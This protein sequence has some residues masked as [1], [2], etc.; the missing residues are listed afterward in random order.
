MDYNKFLDEILTSLIHEDGSDLHLGAGR[1]PAVRINGQLILLSNKEI[2]K[3]EDVLSILKMIIGK[4]KTDKFLET[5]EMDFS[6]AFKETTHLRGNAFFQKV[7]YIAFI[8]HASLLTFFVALS[9][10]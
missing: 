1:K 6:F 5:K 7:K 2:L 9:N 8:N 3:Q 10:Q 4:E